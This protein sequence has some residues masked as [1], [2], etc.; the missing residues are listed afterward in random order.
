MKKRIYTYASLPV[1]LCGIAAVSLS[2]KANEVKFPEETQIESEM[3]KQ[4]KAGG[5]H[6]QYAE[7]FMM[8]AVQPGQQ[9]DQN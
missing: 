2:M 5:Y 3:G 7:V 6:W 4:K 8:A 1:I 9:A